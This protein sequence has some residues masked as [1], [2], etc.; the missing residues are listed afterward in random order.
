MKITFKDKIRHYLN[1]LHIFCRLIKMGVT[2]T[3]SKKI[4][5]WY[6]INI[7]NLILG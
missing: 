4:I 5:V 1:P 3:T 6:E 2:K 7:Y